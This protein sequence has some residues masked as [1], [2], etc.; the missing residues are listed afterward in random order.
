MGK[1]LGAIPS[2][3][4]CFPYVKFLS[5]IQLAREKQGDCMQIKSRKTKQILLI[6]F[7]MWCDHCCNGLWRF[8]SS[9][10]VALLLNVTVIFW[11]GY[12]TSL[13][14]R[15]LSIALA[16]IASYS[17]QYLS[18]G[19][20]SSSLSFPSC[21]IQNRFNVLHSHCSTLIWLTEVAAWVWS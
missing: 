17:N 18:P 12:Q 5:H 14:V 10:A 3:N 15:R 16:P 13:P 6:K 9:K 21:K 8:C 2:Q 1:N 20:Y 11:C 4:P 7:N 19:I